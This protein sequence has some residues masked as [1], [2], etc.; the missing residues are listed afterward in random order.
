[1]AAGKPT[2]RD[3]SSQQKDRLRVRAA[4]ADPSRFADLYEENFE[5]IY[6]F[7]VRRVRQ[8][9]MAEDL[10]SEVFHRAL[11]GLSK[12][13]WRGIPFSVWL[14]RIAANLLTDQW[15]RSSRESDGEPPETIS[16]ADIEEAEHRA[17]LFRLVD[18]LPQDQRRV[19]QLRFVEGRSIAEIAGDMGRS[20]G[21][22]KQLQFRALEKLRSELGGGRGTNHG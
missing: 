15:R 19:V 22:V 14:I 6:A 11:A 21:A 18:R 13:D 8:R 7:I 12:F 20:E 3:R 4:Q 9:E 2:I 10:T 5:R 1:M 17:Q 16:P